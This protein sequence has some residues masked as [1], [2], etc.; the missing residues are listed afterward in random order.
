MWCV[1]CDN[2]LSYCKCPDIDERLRSI[3]DSANIISRWCLGCDKH[4]SRCK[5]ESPV[6]GTRS[7]GKE[8]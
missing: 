5:C 2:D 4:Y 6:W 3:S 7:G 8:K 1:K